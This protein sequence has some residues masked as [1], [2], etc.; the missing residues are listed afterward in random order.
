MGIFLG[1]CLSARGSRGYCED[2]AR[3]GLW[4]R[5]VPHNPPDALTSTAQ[6]ALFG[7]LFSS[8]WIAGEDDT[9]MLRGF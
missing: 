2:I 5:S 8:V 6:T 4:D 3:S 9:G 7:S 1:L